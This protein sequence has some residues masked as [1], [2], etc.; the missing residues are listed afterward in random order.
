[1]KEPPSPDKAALKPLTN[2]EVRALKARAQREPAMFKVGRQGVSAAFVAALDEAFHHRELIKL[3]FDEF[4]E[5][6]RELAGQIASRT[7]SQLLWIVGHVAVFYREREGA[8]TTGGPPPKSAG[9][10]GTTSP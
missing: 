6:K 1:M 2:A 9:A 3:R 5:Q 7:R 4:K 8:G 10:G